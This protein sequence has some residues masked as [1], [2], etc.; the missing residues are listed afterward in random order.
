MF[1]FSFGLL[2][3]FV[4]RFYCTSNRNSGGHSDGAIADPAR[5]QRGGSKPQTSQPRQEVQSETD[6][7]SSIASP[8]FVAEFQAEAVAAATL[9]VVLARTAVWFAALRLRLVHQ[10]EAGQRHACQ[11]DAEFLQRRAA[12]HRLSQ[13]FCKFIEFVVH[14]SFCLSAIFVQD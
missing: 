13:V 1:Y 4:F 3:G 8:H 7:P 14:G 2:V 6:A 12:R 11:A 10:P 9:P 5:R